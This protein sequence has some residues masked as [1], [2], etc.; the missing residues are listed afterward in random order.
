MVVSFLALLAYHQFLIMNNTSVVGVDNGS[1]VYFEYTNT[2]TQ[3][4]KDNGLE[5]RLKSV[6]MSGS[7]S[8]DLLYLSGAQEMVYPASNYQFHEGRL[9]FINKNGG[10]SKVDNNLRGVSLVSSV[11]VDL[12][13][14]EFISDYFIQGNLIYYL[15]GNFCGAYMSSCDNTL[16]VVNTENTT[17]TS[18]ATGIYESHISG[19]SEDGGTIILVNSNGDGGCGHKNFLSFNLIKKATTSTDN[20][21]FC[22]DDKDK[23]VIIDKI[24]QFESRIYPRTAN[25][26]YLHVENNK[27][28]YKAEDQKIIDS[29]TPKNDTSSVETIRVY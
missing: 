11:Q 20:F 22:E 10:L 24:G 9:Y 19:F 28:L 17:S 4:G 16:R 25:A 23:D 21:S 13:K 18:L 3:N 1:I 27:L 8:K 15:A 6:N 26:K 29:I 7:E 14:G 5:V 2:N 12:K